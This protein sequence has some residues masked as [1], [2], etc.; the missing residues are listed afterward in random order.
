MLQEALPAEP[1][2][3]DFALLVHARVVGDVLDVQIGERL[4]VAGEPDAA[5]E[6]VVNEVEVV[7]GAR[8][9]CRVATRPL[10]RSLELVVVV[11]ASEVDAGLEQRELEHAAL[12]RRPERRVGGV[13]GVGAGRGEREDEQVGRDEREQHADR[14]GGAPSRCGCDPG[15]RHGRER[16]DRE[17][18]DRHQTARD[19]REAQR[20]KH[21]PEPLVER[22]RRPEGQQRRHEHPCSEHGGERALPRPPEDDEARH[23]EHGDQPA[24]I[25]EPLGLFRLP[26]AEQVGDAQPSTRRPPGASAHR[27]PPSP[28]RSPGG[29]RARSLPPPRARRPPTPRRRARRGRR[30]TRRGRG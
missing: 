19:A 14:R 13:V 3:G 28:A 22:E 25:D 8:D 29:R 30:R 2:A 21:V 17:V 24:E 16:G 26:P 10:A 7:G 15:H 12:V 1:G 5:G 4:L 27:S 11:H 9:E 23:G 20:R 6:A 18:G